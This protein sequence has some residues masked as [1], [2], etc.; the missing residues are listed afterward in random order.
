MNIKEFA[1][2]VIDTV[3]DS[4]ENNDTD[5]N[6]ELVRYYLDCMEECDE[7]SAPEI[8][9]FSGAKA[10]LT[11]YDYN[12][13][14]ESLDLFLFIHA[15]PLASRIDSRVRTGFNYLREFY[16]QC[17]KKKSPFYG[18]ESEFTSEVQD[19]I[20][21]IR[22][23]KGKVN[24]IR[25]YLLTDGA[26]SSNEIHTL[27]EDEDG[28][29]YEYHVWDIASIYRQDQIKQGNDKIEIDFENDIKYYVTN[30]NS[31]NKE[32]IAPKIQCLKVEDDN[33]SVDTYLAIIS[34]DVLAKI[35][36][37]YR[38]LLLEKNVRAFLRNKSKVN[39]RIMSTIKKTPEM[40]F[41]YNNGISTTASEVE[42]KQTGRIQYITKL[43]D[44]QIV[45]G[46]QTT[47]SIAC[48]TDCDLSKVFVQMKVSVV[49][50]KE[51]YSE[52]VSSISRCANSQTSIKLS[53]FDSGDEYLVKLEKLSKEEIAP[54]SN[55]KWFFE[56][57]RGQYT[58]SRA[59]KASLSELDEKSFKTEYPKKQLLTKTDIAKVMT[60]WEM[61]PHIAC[62][63]REK[64]FTSYMSSLKR[65]H[66]NIDA[67][68]WHNIVALSILYKDIE[69]CFEKR[70][71][72]RGFKSRTVAYTMSA[73]S[74]LTNQNLNIAYIW[75][76]EKVQSQL[77]EIIEREIVK[78]NDFLNQDN[79][80]SFTKNAKCWDDM[81]DMLHGHTV[82]VSLFTSDEDNI[83]EYNDA[84]KGIINQ[85]NAIPAEWWNAMLRWAKEEN[86]LSLIER[87]QASNYIKKIGNNRF[88]KTIN[89]AEKAIALKE[90]AETLGFVMENL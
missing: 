28:V 60:I 9:I 55:T 74:Y 24:M 66:T 83:N 69:A 19:A 5:I 61:K 50:N 26:V 81:K 25:F 63:S 29:L 84:E 58:D 46:G 35:Y 6:T 8:C 56:R 75:K 39:Q 12:D 38:T 44:W 70:C 20:N 59:T 52:I 17:I 48:A 13:E 34:G 80:R 85:A 53:D 42:L 71:G 11:A 27:N 86:R 18:S 49:K 67:T 3:Q 90:K 40:F 31:Q 62:N 43:K 78:V 10:K 65:N 32:Q 54:I 33:P 14:A 87:R 2:Y 22:E 72:Q 41:S 4:A 1:Q 21:I 23:S 79:S 45:N 89:A 7:V 30:K 64:C 36:N 37:Q 51:K 77:E 76:N 82:P 68:Y 16:N 15:T 88:I 73:I 57:M 47:A